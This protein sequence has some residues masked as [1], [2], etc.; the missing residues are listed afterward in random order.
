[1]AA[2]VHTVYLR[3]CF[4]S[5]NRKSFFLRNLFRGHY[6]AGCAELIEA[7]EVCL[8]DGGLARAHVASG[9]GGGVFEAFFGVDDE[10]ALFFVEFLV[11]GPAGEGFSGFVFDED[12][13]A[14][15]AGEFKLGGGFAFVGEDDGGVDGA[16]LGEFHG[17]GVEGETYCELPPD[18]LWLVGCFFAP[19]KRCGGEGGG[20]CSDSFSGVPYVTATVFGALPGAF[21]KAGRG[22]IGCVDG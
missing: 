2:F 18:G 17:D 20:F 22:G 9:E 3:L 21:P 16:A 12:F 6:G 13:D 1:M 10:E 14:L 4:C 8:D 5:V 11:V 7:G 15:A 19:M